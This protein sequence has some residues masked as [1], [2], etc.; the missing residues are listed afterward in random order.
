LRPHPVVQTAGLVELVRIIDGDTRDTSIGRVR[1]YGVDTSERGQPRY[2]DATD[3]LA[4]LAGHA[5]RLEDGPRLTDP[6]GRRLAYVYTDHG[7]SIDAALIADDHARAWT[8]GGQHTGVL[9][10]IERDAVGDD[11]SGCLF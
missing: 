11:V 7:E 10:R 8:R 5:V 1:L 3:L 2:P 4:D 9:T 6:Y